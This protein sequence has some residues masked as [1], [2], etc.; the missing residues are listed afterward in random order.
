LLPDSLQVPD[1]H[2]GS[3]CIFYETPESKGTGQWG[4]LDPFPIDCLVHDPAARKR[5]TER[6]S[7]ALWAA[8]DSAV[9]QVRDI[10]IP[11]LYQV[12]P[13]EKIKSAAF[14]PTPAAIATAT[15]L[16][17]T[18]PTGVAFLP[19]F[20]G[21]IARDRTMVALWVDVTI[22]DNTAEFFYVPLIILLIAGGLAWAQ[23]IPL[24]A[25]LFAAGALV[26]AIGLGLRAYAN[27][28]FL[29]HS[30]PVLA[31]V[32]VQFGKFRKW[33]EHRVEFVHEDQRR[34]VKHTFLKNEV[35]TG[36]ELLI[37]VSNRNAQKIRVV[38]RQRE[39]EPA[40]E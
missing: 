33:V 3:V 14:S 5:A 2:I 23:V 24:P 4:E 13:N 22:E 18:S 10:R 15:P 34:S 6:L 29:H 20:E 21:W 36:E 7:P 32:G 30:R 25:T 17:G 8:L 40:G 19:M 28:S 37:L 1:T 39:K 26:A 38:R 27:W 12:R 31:Q 35:T 9:A 11:G 16:E